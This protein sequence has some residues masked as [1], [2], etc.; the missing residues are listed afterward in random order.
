MMELLPL[1]Y[2]IDTG[3]PLV[4]G[5]GIGIFLNPPQTLVAAL[6]AFA[7]GSLITCL[8]FELFKPA[9]HTA[10]PLLA[11]VSLF[12]G[13]GLYVVV[14]YRVSSG[15]GIRGFPLFAAV[16]FDG[17]AENTTLGVALVGGSIGGPLAIL[18]GIAANNLPEAIGGA[19]RMSEGG[20]SAAWTLSVWTATATGLAATVVGGYVLFS[21]VSALMLAPVQ[22]TG[23]GAVLASLAIEIMP[24][25]YEAG[26]PAVA[27]ATAAGFIV[28][29]VL[30]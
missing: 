18:I 11:A 21:G 27:F 15:D 25:A 20:Q 4:V 24:D 9:F 17:L 29:F 19:K 2:G 6:L 8:A 23:G 7:S 3:L 1:L 28:T 14:K 26:G 10:G 16:V 30:V 12:T 13:T 22:A 5:A